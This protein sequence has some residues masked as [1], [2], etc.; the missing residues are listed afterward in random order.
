VK[1]IKITID[2]DG[3]AQIETTGFKGSTCAL[4]TREIQK[5]LGTVTTDTKKPEF[6]QDNANQQQ[7]RQ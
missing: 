4:A 5:A 1:T 3:Q 7:A 2:Q 6:Y